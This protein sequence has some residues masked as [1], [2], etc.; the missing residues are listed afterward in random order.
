MS[1]TILLPPVPETP[2]QAQH[3][4]LAAASR[5][6]THGQRALPVPLCR[7]ATHSENVPPDHAVRRVPHYS[8]GL[9]LFS[10]RLKRSLVSVLRLTSGQQRD[11]PRMLRRGWLSP[12]RGRLEL[13]TVTELARL[14]DA[15][16]QVSERLAPLSTLTVETKSKRSLTQRRSGVWA[17]PCL[18]D[19]G[20]LHP[21]RAQLSW[22]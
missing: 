10:L 6:A 16:E 17:R 4:A 5:A 21:R 9:T 12:G 19:D 14:P 7:R 22:L 20:P 13:S 1:P 2:R 8:L 3:T 11:C 15:Q 18:C